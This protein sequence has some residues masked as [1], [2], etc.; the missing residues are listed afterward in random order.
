MELN[1][2]KALRRRLDQFLKE[3]DDCIKT[4]PSRAHL[5]TYLGGQVSELPRKSVEPIAL[6]AGVAPRT[7]QEFLGLLQ[8]DHEAMRRR[9]QQWV[10]ENHATEEAI[11]VVDE[12]GFPKKGNE[13]A[14]VQRQ[15]CGATGKRDNCVV[16]VHLGYVAGDFH[17]LIDTDLYLP[18]Q[19]WDQD[20]DRCRKAGIPIEVTYRPKWQIALELLI[21]S[22]AHGVRMKYLAADEVYG[23][24]PG[25]RRGAATLG[26]QYVVEVRCSF[27]GF[28]RRPRVVESAEAGYG[29]MGRPRTRSRLSEPPRRVEALLG[30]KGPVWKRFYIKDTDKGPV[31]WEVRAIRFFPWEENSVGEEGWLLIARNVLDG[32]VKYFFSNA[33]KETP[34]ET[35]LHVA[36][37]RWHIERLFE[38]AKGQVGLD[39]FEVRRYLP[40][41]RHLILSMV[42]LLF[43]VEET[44]RLREKK[45]L[46]ERS[47]SSPGRR[48]AA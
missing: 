12:T 15:Y 30:R 7:L 18:E 35:L 16:S 3:F 41:I 27:T 24:S 26:L 20:R 40:L 31:V 37:S 8:W 45:P 10:M 23:S 9:V 1:E 25:F 17:A 34:L 38:D 44:N 22:I 29:G 33:P 46:V 5:R 48:S 43:L 36:F 21:R 47:T 32:E 11:G 6:E 28:T 13:T 42:S 19:T 14:G 39:H 4:K 2:L